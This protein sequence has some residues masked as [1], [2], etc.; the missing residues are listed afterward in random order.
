MRGGQ[1][2]GRV[3]EELVPLHDRA[4]FLGGER[5]QR[6]P[7]EELHREARR[8]VERVDGKDLHDVRMRE[9]RE[10]APFA[11]ELADVLGLIGEIRAKELEQLPPVERGAVPARDHP[12][13]ALVAQALCPA[14]RP[15]RA[16]HGPRH[17][18]PLGRLGQH[19][20]RERRVAGWSRE[21][22]VRERA[23]VGLLAV[24]GEHGATVP[25]RLTVAGVRVYRR[26]RA[27]TSTLSGAERELGRRAFAPV[28]LETRGVPCREAVRCAVWLRGFSPWWRSSLR[29]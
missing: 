25:S 1:P 28:P 27:P 3:E 11:E 15:E 24:P 6:H 7:L 22:R 5:A 2:A 18:R 17:G 4:P 13:R 16:Q 21:G 8:A 9:L 26:R 20:P 29:L 12:H 23:L 19:R 14:V 10:D